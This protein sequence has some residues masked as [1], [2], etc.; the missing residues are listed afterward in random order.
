MCE[1]LSTTDFT[2]NVLNFA[3]AFNKND[4][5]RVILRKIICSSDVNARMISLCTVHSL[6]ALTQRKS[7][8]HP[9]CSRQSVPCDALLAR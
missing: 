7:V 1:L 2:G 9:G 3:A 4:R 5:L 8:I 6:V